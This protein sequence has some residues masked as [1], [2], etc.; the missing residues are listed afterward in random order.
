MFWFPLLRHMV[1]G[2]ASSLWTPV[3][4]CSWRGIVWLLSSLAVWMS[5]DSPWSISILTSRCHCPDQV[6]EA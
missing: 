2:T 1:Y 6:R 4:S 3:V 5:R